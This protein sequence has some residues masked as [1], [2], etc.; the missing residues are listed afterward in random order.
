MSI[1]IGT[2]LVRRARY[3]G[4]SAAVDPTLV[5]HLLLHLLELLLDD[6]YLLLEKGVIVLLLEAVRVVGDLLL[7]VLPGLDLPGAQVV[8]VIQ[9]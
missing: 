2:C 1:P 3:P 7:H 9:T 5:I 4:S 8:E 6:G